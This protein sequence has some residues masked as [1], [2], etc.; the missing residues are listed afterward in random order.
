[1]LILGIAPVRKIDNIMVQRN[2]LQ[3]KQ[4]LQ[5]SVHTEMDRLFND[6]SLTPLAVKK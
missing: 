2:Y 5:D 3:I 6:P 4:D 1:M